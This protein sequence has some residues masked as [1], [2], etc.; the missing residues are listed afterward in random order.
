MN[1]HELMA[2]VKVS[3]AVAKMAIQSVISSLVTGIYN[4]ADTFFVGKTGDAMQE[5]A[6]SLTKPFFILLRDFSN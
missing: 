6:V 5:A 2:E 3:K 4:R 1:E